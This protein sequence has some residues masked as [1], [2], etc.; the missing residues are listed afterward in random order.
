MEQVRD[1][2]IK[3]LAILFERYHI[4]LFNF[5]LRLTGG[6]RGDS[7]DLVQNVFIRILKYR[8]TFNNQNKFAV[9]LYKIAR[10]VHMDHLRKTL[11]EVSNEERINREPVAREDDIEKIEQ[12]RMIENLNTALLCL[13][14]KKREVLIL[15]RF[16]KLKC[17]EIA[18]IMGCKPGTV[19]VRIIDL[20]K[21]KAPSGIYSPPKGYK[22]KT[23]HNAFGIKKQ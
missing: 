7:E 18:E 15:S 1:G 22:R 9:W 8:T 14:E 16:Q 20:K 3:K 4:S 10:N 23:L 2:N 13:P 21:L 19:K 11:P 17:R 5:F 12:S 6:N